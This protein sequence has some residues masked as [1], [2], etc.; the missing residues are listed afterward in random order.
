MLAAV[1]SLVLTRRTEVAVDKGFT[2]GP[3]TAQVASNTPGSFV[4]VYYG[5]PSTYKQVQSFRPD[6]DVFAESS[7]TV[8]Q[9]SWL[10]V[11]TNMIFWAGLF[12]AVLAPL[13]IFWRPKKQPAYTSAVNGVKTTEEEK[14]S[15]VKTDENPRH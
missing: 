6:G 2:Y 15:Q 14:T 9:W 13:T 5:F 1:L 8:Q 3:P 7:V 11:I 4:T 10:Y 12:T